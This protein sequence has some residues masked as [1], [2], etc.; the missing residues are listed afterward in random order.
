[1]AT[2]ATVTAA[3]KTKLVSDLSVAAIIGNPLWRREAVPAGVTRAAVLAVFAGET[4]DS[5]T[6]Y[7]IGNIVVRIVRRLSSATDENT[8]L[9]GSML[10]D[11]AN[12][13]DRTWWRAVTGVYDVERGP[14][15]DTVERQG[16]VIEYTVT[17]QV[18]IAP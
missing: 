2:V 9:V 3:L 7:A 12:L 14:E 15:L 10:T 1:M 6:S 18:S 16:N 4:G 8:Y 13:M 5:N 17:V 11:Q